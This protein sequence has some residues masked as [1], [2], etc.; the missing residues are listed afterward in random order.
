MGL[1]VGS[2]QTVQELDHPPWFLSLGSQTTEST[3][4]DEPRRGEVNQEGRK[5]GKGWGR[6][7]EGRR[8]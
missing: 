3:A 8:G 4:G 1:M 7:E 2:G 6:R 5:R